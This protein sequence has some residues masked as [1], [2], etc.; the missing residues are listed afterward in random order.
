MKKQVWIWVCIIALLALNVFLVCC[1]LK[2]DDG[3]F[4]VSIMNVLSLDVSIVLSVYVVQS[5]ISRRRGYDFMVKMLDSIVEDLGKPELLDH[6]KNVEAQLLQRYISNRLR[7]IEKA[8]PKAVN[9]DVK[10][11]RDKY[12]SI[13]NFY[14]DHA[15]AK[16]DDAYYE[17]EKTNIVTKV[18]K[19]QLALYGFDV[20]NE[21][22]ESST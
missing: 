15:D 1:G 9:A 4:S 3:F 8:C 18:A 21:R 7:Y 10:Y 22:D 20:G 6:D 5:L 11:I 17:R 2:N 19:V 12:E 13:Q 14:G 16:S